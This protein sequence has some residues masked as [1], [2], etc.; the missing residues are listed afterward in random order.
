M[1]YYHDVKEEDIRRFERQIAYLARK[2]QVVRVSQIKTS[3]TNGRGNPVAITFDDGLSSAV[4]NALPILKRQ[5]LPAAIF[6]PS[7]NLG[8]RPKWEM[9]DGEDLDGDT[10]IEKEELA[11]LDKDGFE[12]FSHT[13]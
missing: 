4:K 5:G 2:H 7:G 12:V 10:V 6:V 13:A 9:E 8:Q 1:L 3:A 11:K